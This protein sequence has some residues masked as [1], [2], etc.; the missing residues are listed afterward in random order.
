[1]GGVFMETFEKKWMQ[2]A[3]FLTLAL[4]FSGTLNI[5][6]LSAFI[7][8]S[9][10]EK[11]SV[12]SRE[13][14]PLE[15]MHFT[16]EQIL[17]SYSRASFSDL[18]SKLEDK[19]LVE[20]GY[21]KRDLALAC[22]SAFHHFFVEKALGGIPLQKRVLFVQG[23]VQIT[24][25]AG[26]QDEHFRALLQFARVE[27]FPYTP[28]GVFQLI[29]QSLYPYESAL[30]EAFYCTPEFHNLYSLVQ[31]HDPFVQKPL[32]VSLLKEGSWDILHQFS[33]NLSL[34]QSYT[35]ETF[36]AFLTSYALDY[37]SKIAADLL[38]RREREYVLKRLEDD[39]LISFLTLIQGQKD[40]AE[41]L[42]K[43]LLSGPRSDRVRKRAAEILCV[44]LEETANKAPIEAQEDKS[45][46]YVLI[47][48]KEKVLHVVQTGEN[49]WKIARKYGVS[50]DSI[51]RL[52]QLES[53]RLRVGKTLQIPEKS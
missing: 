34:S 51:I 30:L 16:N 23:S 18:L 38:W 25:F 48:K 46:A 14:L 42:A 37:S 35:R 17:Q 36:Q 26:L 31:K 10:K 5:S 27:K 15:K 19:D 3:R 28:R 53:D 11:R 29:C 52:N 21:T 41:L 24:A 7:Y 49:L 33:E 8:S 1:M 32:L 39:Q 6:F 43:E 22:L 45:A 9:G 12:L 44:N 47:S 2:R 4:I 20:E 50:V 40:R 13:I